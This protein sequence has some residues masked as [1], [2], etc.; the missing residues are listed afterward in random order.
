[1]NSEPQYYYDPS[2]QN[3]QVENLDQRIWGIRPFSLD[4]FLGLFP[5]DHFWISL[6][7][8]TILVEKPISRR[9]IRWFVGW[10]VIEPILVWLSLFLLSVLSVYLFLA[11]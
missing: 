3:N 6:L 5:L 10:Y 9:F 1:M 2:R 11:S 8:E 4:H 7:L